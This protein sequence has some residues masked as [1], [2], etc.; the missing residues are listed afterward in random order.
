M[1]FFSE[2]ETYYSE[3]LMASTNL[4]YLRMRWLKT[5]SAGGDLVLHYS[6]YELAPS[7]QEP[8]ESLGALCS[9][10]ERV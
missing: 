10:Q 5:A 4:C 8:I 9:W 6:W 3:K 2:E 7:Q 1:C